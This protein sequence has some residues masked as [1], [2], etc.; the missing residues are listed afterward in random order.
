M[1][2]NCSHRNGGDFSATEVMLGSKFRLPR[3]VLPLHYDL[4]LTPD[5]VALTFFGAV[6]IDIKVT[7]ASS[8]ILIN[9][10]DLRL[11]RISIENSNGTVLEGTAE[12]D[13]ELQRTA[14]KF[15]GK[16][17]K[18]KWRPQDQL[19]RCPQR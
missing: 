6:A 11:G 9:T 13:D 19:R 2:K 12:N 17:G 18:G 7:K 16:V 10:K 8:E 1:Y 14:I 5:L 3:H 15:A 4:E